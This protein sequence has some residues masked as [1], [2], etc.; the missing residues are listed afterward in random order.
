MLRPR[1]RRLL[2]LALV[3]LVWVL[4][5][6]GDRTSTVATCDDLAAAFAA[7][8]SG[9][10][11]TVTGT[12]DRIL[13]DDTEGRRHQRFIVRTADGMT[14]LVAHNIDIAPRVPLQRGDT[15][16]VRG[17]Y[18]WNDRGG[19]LHWTHHDPDGRHEAG[20]VEVGGRRYR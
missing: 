11:L 2:V 9:V 12:V 19:L 3:A 13:A 14:V 7:H 8:R 1:H 4:S 16:T 20:W 17:E 18:E 15:V 6:R 5:H 10:E